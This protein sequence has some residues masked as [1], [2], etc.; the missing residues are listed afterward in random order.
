MA[1]SNCDKYLFSGA[2]D[3]ALKFWDAGNGN[4]L[5]TFEAAHN[6]FVLE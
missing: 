5:K 1:V 2:N 6:G 3:K 4:L